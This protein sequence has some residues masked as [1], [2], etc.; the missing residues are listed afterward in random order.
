MTGI[1]SRVPPKGNF[2]FSYSPK[3]QSIMDTV[4]TSLDFFHGPVAEVFRKD[5]P[6]ISFLREELN[7]FYA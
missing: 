7:H 1:M 3:K 2:P 4:S 5:L 6:H